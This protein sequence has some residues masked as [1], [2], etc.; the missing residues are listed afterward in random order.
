[1][2]VMVG[3]RLFL[4]ESW[5]SAPAQLDTARLPEEQREYR[6]KPEIDPIRSEGVAS[7]ACWRMLDTGFLRHSDRV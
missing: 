7:A 4:S 5:T 6:T 1:V 3:L 2:P